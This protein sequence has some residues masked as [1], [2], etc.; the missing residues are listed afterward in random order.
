[1]QTSLL[2]WF[3]KYLSDWR[4]LVVFTIV[5]VVN[6]LVSCVLLPNTFSNTE[7]IKNFKIDNIFNIILKCWKFNF[8]I[9]V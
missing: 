2:K 1:M 4:Q 5:S 3:L 8:K 6:Y 7:F 9:L